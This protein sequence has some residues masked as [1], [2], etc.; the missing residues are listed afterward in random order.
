MMANAMLC[1][2]GIPVQRLQS[3]VVDSIVLSI[4]TLEGRLMYLLCAA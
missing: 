3:P 2:R 4:D 1:D